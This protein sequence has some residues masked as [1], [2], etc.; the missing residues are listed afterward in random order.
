MGSAKSEDHDQVLDEVLVPPE[1]GVNSFDFVVDGPDESKIPSGDML[2]VTV[3]MVQALYKVC[4][5]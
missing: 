3:V 5:E 1:L 2:G 4:C